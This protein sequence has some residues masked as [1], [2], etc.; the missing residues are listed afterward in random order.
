MIQFRKHFEALPEFTDVV[1]EDRRRLYGQEKLEHI[2]TTSTTLKV[3]LYDMLEW[4]HVHAY[5]EGW[6]A[7]VEDAEVVAMIVH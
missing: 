5:G 1:S 4:F 3:R 7:L 2:W 6:K